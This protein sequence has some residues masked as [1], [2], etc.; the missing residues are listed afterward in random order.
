MSTSSLVERF[1]THRNH[2]LAV[3]YRVTGSVVDAEDAVQESWIRLSSA[4]SDSIDDLRAWLTTVVGRIC[5]DRLKSAASRRESYVGQWLPEPIVSTAS[6]PG[7]DPLDVVVRTEDTRLAALVV[8][9]TLSPAQRVAF[10][11]HDGFSVPFDAI[12]SVLDVTP[13]AARQLASRARKQVD[14]APVP[15]PDAEHD[16]AV[17]RFMTALATG[18]LDRVVAALHPDCRTIGDS[19]GTTR[20]AVQIVHGPDK[21]ARFFLGLIAKY[22]PDTLLSMVPASVNGQLGYYSHG[23]SGERGFPARAG[24]FTVRDGLVWASYDFANPAKLKGVTRSLPSTEPDTR[25]PSRNPAR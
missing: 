11:L 10:V 18:D 17:T 16:I 24:G 2:L 14:H 9:D 8:L 7:D 4:E 19:G 1:Q 21:C 20:T 13:A 3:G 23:V 12:A 15:V 5:L 6:A 22:G 25:P